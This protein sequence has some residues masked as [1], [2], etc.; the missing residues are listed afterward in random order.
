MRLGVCGLCQA[1]VPAEVAE[2]VGGLKELTPSGTSV[3]LEGQLAE[4]P[5]G[6]KQVP[7]STVLASLCS[8]HLCVGP[9]ITSRRCCL[10]SCDTCRFDHAATVYMA[11][12]VVPHACMYALL[13]APL[14]RT[15]VQRLTLK[16][17][18]AAG[19]AE[20]EPGGACWAVRQQRRQV[21][22]GQEEDDVRVPARPHAP[23]PAH[24]HH[25][26]GSLL[27]PPHAHNGKRTAR[28][29]GKPLLD[30][31]FCGGWLFWSQHMSA[32]LWVATA[33]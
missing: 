16:L 8:H 24:Q 29:A 30:A 14:A 13:G 15:H 11:D 5:P 27:L 17:I 28:H 25:R 20:G 3:L 23:A 26:V 6:T 33:G 18:C 19:G 22:A 31:T 10:P 1:V 32:V 21:R 7:P 9:I 4:T 2:A 12:R